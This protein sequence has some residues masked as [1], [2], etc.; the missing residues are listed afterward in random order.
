MEHDKPKNSEARLRANKKYLKNKYE[1]INV[2]V[3]LGTKDQ[4]RSKATELGYTSLN[5][6]IK[7]AVNEKI[8]RG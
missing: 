8:E 2:A 4:W 1:G 5:K 6:F 3:P 7:D